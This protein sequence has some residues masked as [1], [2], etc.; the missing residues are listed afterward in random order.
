MEYSLDLLNETEIGELIENPLIKKMMAVSLHYRVIGYQEGLTQCDYNYS[1]DDTLEYMKSNCAHKD[2]IKMVFKFV[3]DGFELF[4]D[5]LD[6]FDIKEDIYKVS[7]KDEDITKNTIKYFNHE[8]EAREYYE[9]LVENT[10]GNW[11]SVSFHSTD[12][13]SDETEWTIEEE[14]FHYL[15]EVLTQIS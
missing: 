14:M 10:S 2:I 11:V 15:D 8:D 12:D 3:E 4:N 6:I 5:E 9:N 1:T 13:Y 7:Y